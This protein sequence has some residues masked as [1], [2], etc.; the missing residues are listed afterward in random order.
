MKL[1]SMSRDDWVIGGVAVLLV[2]DLLFLPWFDV[3]FGPLSVTST[4]TGAPDGWLG[5]LAV[6]SALALV[7]DLA[8]ERLAPATRA[9]A[10]AGSR[11]LTRLA[12]AGACALFVVLKFLF[13][14]HFSLF[15][16]GFWGAVILTGALALL[17]VR[18]HTGAWPG[19]ARRGS[20]VP[21]ST[22]TTTSSL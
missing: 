12:L 10:L 17:S 21:D 6:L 15:G 4:A 7:A 8:L 5:V 3:S 19:L 16:L 13:H 20:A 2:V 11:T 9:P 22:G 18:A 14:V 1:D